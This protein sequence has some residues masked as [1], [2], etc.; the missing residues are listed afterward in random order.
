MAKYVINKEKAS[1]VPM[2]GREQRAFDMFVTL[3]SNLRKVH[4]LKKIAQECKV[5]G[6]VL[7]GWIR[8][9]NWKERLETAIAKAQ[10][11]AANDGELTSLLTEYLYGKEIAELPDTAD[12]VKT[13]NQKK[14]ERIR[15]T[16]NRIGDIIYEVRTYNHKMF[17]QLMTRRGMPYEE[18]A[19][20]HKAWVDSLDH[21]LKLFGIGTIKELASQALEDDTMRRLMT[22]EQA[23]NNAGNPQV[24]VFIGSNPAD[25]LA[26]GSNVVLDSS[27]HDLILNILVGE[28][29]KIEGPKDYTGLKSGAELGRIEEATI[30]DT[31]RAD[32]EGE[33]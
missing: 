31:R 10:A 19:V 28:G 3:D 29:R 6:V 15:K 33:E 24:G 14:N 17:R 22:A 23:V 9:G 25:M 12:V 11:R 27:S 4:T 1:A 16:V 7:A 20:Y 32:K 2:K 5:S 8:K 13:F 21:M 30:V 18:R 26:A